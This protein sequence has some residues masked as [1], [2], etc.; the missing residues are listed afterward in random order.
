NHTFKRMTDKE[1]SRAYGR[2]ATQVLSFWIYNPQAV[3]DSMALT[4]SDKDGQEISEL[5]V[6]MN[7]TGWRTIGV[8]LNKD[9]SEV[10]TSSFEKLVF[11]A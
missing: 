7:F 1:A 10:V 2:G 9:F 4:L 6:N 3:E 5:N 8:S 11:T